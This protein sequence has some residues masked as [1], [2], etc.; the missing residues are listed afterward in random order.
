MSYSY[1]GSN[2][3]KGNPNFE[4]QKLRPSNK[5]T[6]DA[7]GEATIPHYLAGYS[8]QPNMYIAKEYVPPKTDYPDREENPNTKNVDLVGGGFF[9]DFGRGFM[10]VINPVAKVATKLAPLAPL[11]I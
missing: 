8:R 2:A 6:L 1:Y 3:R 10:S 4:N 11:L 9:K 5:S 7:I